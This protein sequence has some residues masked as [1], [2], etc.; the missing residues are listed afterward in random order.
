M[1]AEE[2]HSEVVALLLESGASLEAA[3]HS[4]SRPSRGTGPEAAGRER[5]GVRSDD[6]SILVSK[7]K[8]CCEMKLGQVEVWGSWSDELFHAI[9]AELI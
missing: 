7:S 6:K 5:L 3:D 4:G 9:C 8:S 2:G 1:A